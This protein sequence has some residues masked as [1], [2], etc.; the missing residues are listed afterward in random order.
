MS[1]INW[2]TTSPKEV[3]QFI[4]DSGIIHAQYLR[5]FT[6]TSP[7]FITCFPKLGLQEDLERSQELD[8]TMKGAKETQIEFRQWLDELDNQLLNFVK[9]HPN[10]LQGATFKKPPTVEQ[11]EVM[12]KRAFK[13]RVSTKTG[14]TYPDSMVC[15]FK[16]GRNWGDENLLVLDADLNQIAPD[17]VAYNHLVRVHL[18]YNGPYCRG[19][20]FGNS[21]ALQAVQT[22][23]QAQQIQTPAP[24]PI[25]MFARRPDDTEMPTLDY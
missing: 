14:K 19:G 10:V 1:G 21:W 23:G 9:T 25:D 12:L 2:Q 6:L 11:L 17:T 3:I 16:P 7:T 18:V 20:S 15:R 8:I 5:P 4:A 13:P 22:F 24:T